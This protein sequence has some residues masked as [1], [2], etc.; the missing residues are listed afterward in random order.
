MSLRHLATAAAL[1][2][3]LAFAPSV[4]ARAAQDTETIDRTVPFPS[5]GTLKLNTFSGR[6]T[7]TATNGHDVVIKAVRR[8]TRDRLDHIKLDISTTGST[9][10]I[11]ANKRDDSWHDEHDNVVSTDFDIQV[12]ASAVL[13]VNSFSSPLSVTGIAGNQRLKTFSATITVAHAK[14]A[15]DAESFSGAIDVDVAAAGTEPDLNLHTFSGAI[16][17]RL[18]PNAKG[19]VEFESF[20]GRLDS[21]VALM[22]HSSSRRNVRGELNGGSGRT[23]K[24]NTFSGDVKLRK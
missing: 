14:G 17:A 3:G 10:R 24:L 5:S 16:T 23:I 6:V 18:D 7:I 12:P 13:D 20:S 19:S 9:V 21:D 11:D 15:I 1:V 8:G 22:M 4:S 2:A